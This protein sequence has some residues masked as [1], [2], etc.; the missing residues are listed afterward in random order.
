VARFKAM[1]GRRFGYPEVAQQ[2]SRLAGREVALTALGLGVELARGV[3][4]LLDGRR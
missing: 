2:V 4:S 3:R 1:S